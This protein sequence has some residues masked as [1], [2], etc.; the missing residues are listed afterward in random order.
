M[1]LQVT[2]KSRISARSWTAGLSTRI[3]IPLTTLTILVAKGTDCDV[4]FSQAKIGHIP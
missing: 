3:V 4:F 2:T 1:S